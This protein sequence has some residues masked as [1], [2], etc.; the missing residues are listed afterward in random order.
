MAP[1]SN[2]KKHKSGAFKR[3]ECFKKKKEQQLISKHAT[4]F[5][6]EY[7][8][9][10]KSQFPERPQSSKKDVLLNDIVEVTATPK[11]IVEVT[12]TPKHIVEVTASPKHIVEVTASP[13]HIVE[14]TASPKH[15]SQDEFVITL[16]ETT[17]I[18]HVIV[19]SEI[20]ELDKENDT[21]FA[22]IDVQICSET[23]EIDDVA[24]STAASIASISNSDQDKVVASTD[25][26][27][28]PKQNKNL[29][30]EYWC[31]HGPE[32]CKNLTGEYSVSERRY[33]GGV[34]RSFTCEMVERIMPNGETAKKLHYL[35]T[36]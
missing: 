20:T 31:R 33:S 2:S 22:F 7:R 26:A 6:S 16:S 9:K 32:M 18:C 12:A 29:L 19:Q 24:S 10:A 8:S 34:K 15:T 30:Q 25:P 36:F 5:W 27:L 23:G 11:H 13:K 21:E 35:F 4:H 28:W 3:K 14:V 1:P 17:D